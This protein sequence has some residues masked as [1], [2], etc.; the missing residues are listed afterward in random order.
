MTTAELRQMQEEMEER[1]MRAANMI[2]G[3]GCLVGLLAFCALLV[4]L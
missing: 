2:V 3:A 4:Q 1:E